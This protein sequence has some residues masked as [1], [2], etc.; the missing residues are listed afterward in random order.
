M[1]E[2]GT[3]RQDVRVMFLGA[4]GEVTGSC[5][6]VDAGGHTLLVDC[7]MLQGHGALER[8][9]SR[10]IFRPAEVEAVLLTHAH[11]DH[12]GLLPWLCKHGFGGPIFATAGTRDLC[13]VI[14]ADS[15]HLQVEDAAYHTRK[16]LPSAEPLY[17]PEDVGQTM[18]RFVAI[19][20]RWP[21]EPAQGVEVEF[22]DAGHI[23]GA[24]SI[25]VSC[26]EASVVFSGDIG[27]RHH[28][29]IRDPSPPSSAGTVVTEATYGDKQHP[30]LSEAVERLASTINE[31]V[32]RGGVILMPVFAVGRCQTMLFELGRLMRAGK[33]PRL[34]VFLDS[35]LA[36]E[37]VAVFNRHKEYFDDATKALIA[38]GIDPLAFEG[39][40]FCRT[41]E[42]SKRLNDLRQPAIVM[43]G[44]GMCTGGRIRHHLRNRLGNHQD[45]VLFVGYQAAGTLGRLLVDGARQVKLFGEWVDVNARVVN[46]AGFSAHADAPGLL[47]WLANIRGVRRVL[48][49]HAEPPA[50][51]A[52]ATAVEGR[53]GV[54]PVIAKPFQLMSV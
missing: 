15:A 11:L 47:D 42:E 34:P 44:S 40:H 41:A 16:G 38:E 20:Y 36:I 9:V 35:P 3:N 53:L 29:L 39:L 18:A 46:I 2:L 22:F 45:T 49:D 37:A 6:L 21:F 25:A 1:A 28:P 26:G 43:A 48:V 31:A 12:C 5:T 14:L 51:S 7:G 23:L 50:A 30:P 17:V 52:Y 19:D 54:R 4:A 13:Q 8:Q 33:I 10:L 24:A 27:P 32:E